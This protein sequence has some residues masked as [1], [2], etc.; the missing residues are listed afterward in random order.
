MVL[1]VPLVFVAMN[2]VAEI[3]QFLFGRSP[4][5]LLA[6]G[7]LAQAAPLPKV[8]I[9]IPACREPAEMLKE[10][11]DSVA[12]LDYPDFECIVLINNT[13]DE[14]MVKPVEE[15]CRLLGPRFKFINA[16]KV[17][18]FKARALQIALDH[19]DPPPKSS[20]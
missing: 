5:R 3:A 1:L 12:R 9:H 13:P 4:N 18:G 20:A 6:A 11:L 8:S 16:G 10:T 15:H 14:A 7:R 2:H 17:D 19:T